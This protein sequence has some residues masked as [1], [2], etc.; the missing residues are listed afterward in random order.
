MVISPPYSTETIDLFKK[1]FCLHSGV[2]LQGQSYGPTRQLSEHEKLKVIP[3]VFS[4]IP[5]ALLKADPSR[6]FKPQIVDHLEQLRQPYDDLLVEIIRRVANQW[7]ASS[8]SVGL[9][10]K[11]GIEHIRADRRFY[12]KI[13][14]RQAGRCRICG[15]VFRSGIPQE[16][17]HVIPYRLIGDIPNGDNY[18]ILCISC[19]QG[20]GDALSIYLM[21]ETYGWVYAERKGDDTDGIS[22]KSRYST[23]IR[24]KS[25]CSVT[26]LTSK[27]STLSVCKI[28]D[29]SLPITPNLRTISVRE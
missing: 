5:P 9:R 3:V 6:P 15:T 19:N 23:L 25:T 4:L 29:S 1:L 21:K 20:K 2:R 14:E 26:G 27:E 11:K 24:D 16:L 10:R 18:Q 17:D 28:T 8:P 22:L 12:S 13:M 7:N